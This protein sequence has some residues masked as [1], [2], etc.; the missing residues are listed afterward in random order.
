MP[1]CASRAVAW[2]RDRA[3]NYR[4]AIEDVLVSMAPQAAGL[5]TGVVT[6]VL[7]A[8]GL[9]AAGMGQYALVLSICGLT[10]QLSDL[11]IGRTAVRFAARAAALGETCLQMAV[12]RWA[13][14]I[15]MSMALLMSVVAFI[16]APWISQRFWHAAD[17]A[18][19]VRLGLWIGILG[20]LA[21]VPT[22][23]FQALKRFRVNATVTVVQTLLTF[24]G[25]LILAFLRH[26]SV[27]AVIQVSVVT[28]ALGAF[29]FLVLVPKAAL[30]TVEDLRKPFRS[31][32]AG[33]WKAPD[34]SA[35][36]ATSL[37]NTGPTTFAF[38]MVLSSVATAVIL[39][40]DV[41]LM[42]Y[43]LDKPQIGIYQVATR[44]TLPLTML[45]GAL[46]TALWPRASALTSADATLRLLRGTFKL[47][48]LTA[49]CGLLYAAFVPLLMP[50]LFGSEYATGILLGQLLCLR[51]CVALLMCPIQVIGYSLGLVR[52]YWL[53]NLL[54]LTVTVTM[55]VLLLPRMGAVGSAIALIANDV[56][57]F[58]MIGGLILR[59]SAAMRLGSDGSPSI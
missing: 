29:I 25:I 32:L 57:G 30:F 19:I 55:N 6:S 38:Y 11:G 28:T 21:A 18:P 33:L 8:R 27:T 39:R 17:L 45:L 49:A 1:L 52:I 7:I 26:W 12:L 56:V 59:H 54:Q 43:F 44:F 51:Y 50:W 24:I 58:A 36:S 4:Q 10:A 14:R 22:V 9:G 2:F 13:F 46:N 37:D 40:A 48:A 34:Q 16:L 35:V 5:V 42:G 47:T 23:Y 41:W 31:A 20:A 3:L 15:R 53:V